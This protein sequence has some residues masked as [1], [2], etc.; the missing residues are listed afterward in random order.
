V[1]ARDVRE[2]RDRALRPTSAPSADTKEG[3]AKMIHEFARDIESLEL[4]RNED[5]ATIRELEIG[6]LK[7]PLTGSR[8]SGGRKLVLISRFFYI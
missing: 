8:E 2:K 3:V 7:G 4:A 1:Y 6:V 5:H